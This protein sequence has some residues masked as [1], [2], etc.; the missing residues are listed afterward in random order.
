MTLAPS[1]QRNVAWFHCFS[2]IAGDMALGCLIDAGADLEEVRQ[3]I[4]RVPFSGW[5]L[6]TE[7]VLRGGIA[8]TRAVVSA[9]DDVVVRTHANIVELVRGARLPTRVEARSLAVFGVLADVEGRLHRR[10]AGQVHFHEVGGHDAIVDVVGTAAALEVLGVDEVVASPVATGSGMVRTSHGLLPNPAPAVVRLLEGV[11]TYGRDVLVELTTPTGAAILAALASS[12]G[13][14][15]AMEIGG[16]GFGAGSQDLDDLPNCTQVVLGA[17]GPVPGTG[18]GG[19]PVT[20]LEANLDDATGEQL[21]HALRSLLDAGAHDAWITPVVMKKG[22]PGHTIHVLADPSLGEALRDLLRVTTGSFGVRAL[23]GERWPSAR[24]IAPVEVAGFPV[25]V[26]A[27]GGRVKAEFDDVVRV[28]A[29]T[30][31][32]LLEVSSR[33]EQAWRERGAD[34]RENGRVGPTL[35]PPDGNE[36]A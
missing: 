21:A 31:L 4:R 6:E 18:T 22:R 12:F 19:Q 5:E 15:P 23:H 14:L 8:C 17:I 36:P 20:V 27:G 1:P 10:P 13:P 24:T 30:G 34:D 25:Q 26:K 16:T 33:A 2:G 32:P 29:E 11:P 3:L 7:P 35:V 28:S 9:P